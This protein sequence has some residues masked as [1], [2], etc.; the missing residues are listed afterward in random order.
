MTHIH[1]DHIEIPE[2]W[3]D[4]GLLTFEQFCTLI[5]TPQRTVR[6]WRRRGVGPP[7]APLRRLRA[8]LPQRGRRPPLPGVRS[9]S[10]CRVKSEPATKRRTDLP[11]YLSL[12]EA[13]EVMSMS[14][15]TIRRR[16]ADG[17]IPAYTCG[18]GTLRIRL[19]ELEE[20]MRR[21]PT[22]ERRRA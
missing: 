13:A 19:D 16:V 22:T 17:T 14:V 6:D 2:E 18:R 10:G 3:S 11:V 1:T 7:V 21:V 12:V 5:H 4:Q 15:K 8:P 20:A 9:D